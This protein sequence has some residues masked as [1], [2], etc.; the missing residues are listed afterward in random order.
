MTAV[1]A[2]MTGNRRVEVA[3]RGAR[4]QASQ[5]SVEEIAVRTASK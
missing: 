1:T 3:R 5:D 2:T 4:P